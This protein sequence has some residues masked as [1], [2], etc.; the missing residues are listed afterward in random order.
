MSRENIEY[1]IDII[2]EIAE[3]PLL[4]PFVL[5]S[6]NDLNNVYFDNAEQNFLTAKRS[7]ED[8]LYQSKNSLE[9]G[10]THELLSELV[11]HL[12]RSIRLNQK[13]TTLENQARSFHEVV[14]QL[15]L[16][17][18]SLDENG[19]LIAANRI[20]NQLLLG[21]SPLVCHNNSLYIDN[22]KSLEQLNQAIRNVILS[23]E[24]DG[25]NVVNIAY[26]CGSQK[27]SVL[28]APNEQQDGCYLLLAPPYLNR[29]SSPESISKV[30]GL[31]QAES[32]IVYFLV[33]GLSVDEISVELDITPN[34]VRAHLKSAYS[35]TETKGQL[36][37]AMLVLQGPASFAP[38]KN[39]TEQE[40]TF[41][42]GEHNDDAQYHEFIL[43]DGRKLSYAIYG[44][45]DS[46]SSIVFFHSLY[47]SRL[48]NPGTVSELK[49]YGVQL[50]VPDRPGYGCSDPSVKG[51]L[52]SFSDDIKQLVNHLGKT[53]VHLVGYSTGGCYCSAVAYYH[54]E[55][56]LSMTLINSV[57]PYYS[58]ADIAEVKPI[59]VKLLFALGFI[60]SSIIEP[61]GSLFTKGVLR[62]PRKYISNQFGHLCH[63]DQQVIARYGLIDRYSMWFA[64]GVRNGIAG[65]VSDILVIT[66]KWPFELSNITADT[67]IWYGTDDKFVPVG[68]TKN[69]F[70]IQNKTIIPLDGKGH[71]ALFD[72]WS[73]V[74][75]Q[76]SLKTPGHAPIKP[77]Y[78]V[79]P[80]L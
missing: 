8:E 37:L 12:K 23:R 38:V 11:P 56:C 2:Y 43:K 78:S 44:R 20:A 26:P 9:S 73:E 31:S 45:N 74:L 57:A 49:K 7:I 63:Y 15:P 65:I 14:N 79:I 70:G 77:N 6:L 34:T 13:F 30:H 25:I 35:K 33:N 67:T 50:I 32:N 22:P 52:I 27:I 41:S 68:V 19:Q 61:I 62:N 4:W 47:A 48:Q 16:G 58:M 24:K 17:F 29:V 36:E 51:T 80:Q 76:L 72:I 53:S 5:Q 3:D 75:Y 69:L 18:I 66:G 54:P 60:S 40:Y 28:V 71:M 1:L 55:I 59:P 10:S 42:S 46:K 21:Q 64:D 39:N